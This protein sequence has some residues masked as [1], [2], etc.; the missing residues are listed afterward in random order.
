MDGLTPMNA[1]FGALA[2]SDGLLLRK[3]F[4]CAALHWTPF[5]FSTVEGAR[6]KKKK[7][8]EVGQFQPN[9]GMLVP[10][11]HLLYRHHCHC[12]CHRRMHRLEMSVPVV[13]VVALL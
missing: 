3:V 7:M 10:P 6:Q 8:G 13:V 9:D 5:V 12:H 2:D 11:M 1:P 4:Y